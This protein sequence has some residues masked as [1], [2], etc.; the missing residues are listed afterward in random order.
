MQDAFAHC[1]Q[2]VRVADKD[3][4]LATLFAPAEHRGALYALYAFNVE[5]ARVREIA[6]EPLPAKSACNG[7]AKCCA[8]SRAK[9]R[10]QI[11]SQRRCWQ[12]IERYQLP[13]PRFAALVDA[14]IFDLYDDPM[15]TAADL[16]AY[17]VKTS[18]AVFAM[19]AQI[20]GASADDIARPAGIAYAVAALLRAFPLMPRGGGS[21]CR[22]NCWRAMGRAPRMFC[23]QG[24]AGLRAALAEMRKHARRSISRPWPCSSRQRPAVIIPALLPASVVRLRTR[25]HGEFRPLRTARR[26]AMAPPMAHVACGARRFAHRRLTR[27][28]CGKDR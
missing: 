2:L 14:R 26:A 6:R 22:P 27:Q 7:G 15:A 13:V 9:R 23:P 12:T 16:E 21:M 17:A 8:A 18:S 4:F 5:V 19:A 11:R 3:R 20:L 1:E 28:T 10:P 25:P 24:K